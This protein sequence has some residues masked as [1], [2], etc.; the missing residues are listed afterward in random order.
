MVARAYLQND[1]ELRETL[2]AR[3][4]LSLG[5]MAREMFDGKFCARL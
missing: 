1:P 3:F 4:K 2:R 5:D